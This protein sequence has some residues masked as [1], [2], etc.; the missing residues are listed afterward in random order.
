MNYQQTVESCSTITELIEVGKRQEF[1]NDKLYY[2]TR[3]DK[4]RLNK[5]LD[6]SIVISYNSILDDNFDII[7]SH[8]KKFHLTDKEMVK[9][10][11]QPHKLC[12]DIYGTIE[13]VPL[14][15]R[16][17]AMTS[18]LDFDKQDIL[19]FEKSI[20]TILNE[21]SII[22]EQDLKDNRYEIE[23]R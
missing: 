23:R 6:A 10:K 11:Y 14:V 18:L 3:I 12:Y 13:I 21:L 17:N 16:I 8:T 7:M 1:T 20:F 15:L 19:L 4:S 9:Y 2:Q 22:Y 5:N